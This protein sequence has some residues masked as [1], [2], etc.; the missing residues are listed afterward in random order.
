MAELMSNSDL[1]LGAGGRTSWERCCLGL[2]SLVSTLSKDQEEVITTLS[3]LGC[4][5]NLGKAESVTAD[6]YIK[7]IQTLDEDTL[8]QMSDNCL[9][10]VDG[11]GISRIKRIIESL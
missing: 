7:I 8:K 5:V 6:N 4:A 9:E 11:K 10:L 3:K 2:P 1:S